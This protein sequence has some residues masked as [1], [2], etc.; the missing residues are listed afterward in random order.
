MKTKK[1]EA[2]NIEKDRIVFI[3]LGVFVIS[4]VVLMAFTWRTPLETF[5]DK[6]PE[7]TAEVPTIH[8]LVEPERID[9][10]KVEIIVPEKTVLPSTQTLTDDIEPVD[11][12]DANTSI[13]VSTDP[14]EGIDNTFLDNFPVGDAPKLDMPEMYPDQEAAFDGNWFKYLS[15]ELMYPEESIIYGEAGKIGIEFVVSKTGEISNIKILEGSHK[16]KDLRKEAIRV[17]KNAP[18]WKPGVKNG[19]YVPTYKRVVINFVL[20]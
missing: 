3:Q 15:N 9:E 11:N 5:K 8:V 14:I 1:N 19:E 6:L 7:R 13:K 20:N 12:T 16:S 10:P 4:S 18:S 17:V 2:L